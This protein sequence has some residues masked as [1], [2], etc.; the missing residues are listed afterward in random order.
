[1]Y[2]NCNNIWTFE[3]SSLS[4]R[5]DDLLNA[6]IGIWK[7]FIQFRLCASNSIRFSRISI[8]LTP[9]CYLFELCVLFCRFDSIFYFLFF[10]CRR[11]MVLFI[12]NKHA[13]YCDSPSKQTERYLISIASSYFYFFVCFCDF[14]ISGS[15]KRECGFVWAHAF[16]MQWN[17]CHSIVICCCCFFLLY[18]S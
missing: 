4:N 10:L 18:I 7:T 17:Q 15:Q 16:P 12:L 9:F 1:M 5:V 13:V 11:S 6:L 14:H 3:Y 2:S 8:D